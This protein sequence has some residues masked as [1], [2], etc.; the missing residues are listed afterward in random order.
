MA[1]EERNI[2]NIDLAEESKEVNG[3]P[4]DPMTEERREEIIVE[5]TKL[6]DEIKTLRQ[7]LLRKETQLNNLRTELG[8]TRWARLQN[9]QA[10]QKSKQAISDAGNKTS[11][12]L[13]NVGNITASKWQEIKESQRYQNVSERFWSTTGAVKAKLTGTGQ[14]QSQEETNKEPIVDTPTN[15]SI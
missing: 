9:S 3:V 5:V 11:Q 6:E 14:T 2:E 12:A 1:T 8:E 4:T 13:K 10:V 7:A 15:T